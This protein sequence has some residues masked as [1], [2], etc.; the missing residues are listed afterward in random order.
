MVILSRLL[1][2]REIVIDHNLLHMIQDI[3]SRVIDHIEG[4]NGD[5]EVGRL[6]I[7]HVIPEINAARHPDDKYIDNHLSLSAGSRF[8]VAT[9]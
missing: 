7:N 1:L 8:A 5:E 6:L 9:A 2:D 4:N 3:M